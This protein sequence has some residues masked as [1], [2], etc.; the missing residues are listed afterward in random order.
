MCTDTDWQRIKQQ[1]FVGAT[2]EGVVLEHKPFGIFLDIGQEQILG[3]IQIV[4]F[5]S[6]GRMEQTQYPAIGA[7]ISCKVLGYKEFGKQIWL[8]PNL[9]FNLKTAV[10]SADTNYPIDSN[11][12][13]RF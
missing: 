5:N 7:K 1:L 8:A 4:D 6:Q 9:P 2:L 3:L 11:V 10:E 12:E 13:N